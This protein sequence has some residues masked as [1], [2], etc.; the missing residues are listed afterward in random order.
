MHRKLL[1]SDC[2]NRIADLVSQPGHGESL[3]PDVLDAHVGCGINCESGFFHTVGGS[4]VSL[5]EVSGTDAKGAFLG[6]DAEDPGAEERTIYDEILTDMIALRS[7]VGDT[8]VAIDVRCDEDELSYYYEEDEVP[9][10]SLTE[11][12]QNLN[13]YLE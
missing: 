8:D 6:T 9:Q 11:M 7:V 3:Y 13:L 10:Q 2:G 4:S 12:I 5:V 1:E